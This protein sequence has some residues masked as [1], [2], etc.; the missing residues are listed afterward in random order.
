MFSASA[1]LSHRLTSHPRFPKSEPGKTADHTLPPSA[2]PAAVRQHFCAAMSYDWYQPPPA[3]EDDLPPY[4]FYHDPV[5]EPPFY[6]YGE[7][8][9]TSFPAAHYEHYQPQQQ[10]NDYYAPQIDRFLPNHHSTATPQLPT[11]QMSPFKRG[12]FTFSVCFVGAELRR[13]GSPAATSAPGNYMSL[14]VHVCAVFVRLLS[15]RRRRSTAASQPRTRDSRQFFCCHSP[16][17]SANGPLLLVLA[18][19]RCRRRSPS[20][21]HHRRRFA[22]SCLLVFPRSVAPKDAPPST[23]TFESAPIDDARE[24]QMNTPDDPVIHS[25]P[26]LRSPNSAAAAAAHRSATGVNGNAAPGNMFSSSQGSATALMPS[27]ALH[28]GLGRDNSSNDSPLQGGA[29]SGDMSGDMDARR[30]QKTCR[31]CGD[32]ATGY[33]FNVITCESCKAF[34]RRNALRPKLQEFKCPYSDDCEINAV[35]RRFC[36]KCRLRKCFNVGMKKEWILNEEQLRRRKNS[37]LNNLAGHQKQPHQQIKTEVMTPDMMNK[38]PGYNVP[39][40]TPMSIIPPG[41]PM[42][43]Q[44]HQ[45]R[46][47]DMPMISPPGGAHNPKI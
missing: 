2:Q 21:E 33:N 17:V 12:L 5:E 36:Q 40:S 16:D 9:S 25:P 4:Q 8:P 35:S 34:F 6:P 7:M 15:N 43:M 31:V 19:V 44:Q 11:P 30:R 29:S 27:S 41:N 24:Q 22:S 39:L 45:R 32:H 1:R 18:C 14:D 10:P 23:W 46:S 13:L 3:Q 28:P 20:T 38:P 37:R 42:M 47:I 26:S